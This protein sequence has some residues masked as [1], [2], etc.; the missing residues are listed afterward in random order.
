MM[1]NVENLTSEQSLYVLRFLLH[2][3]GLDTRGA[4]MAEMPVAYARLYPSV[5][6]TV[7][8][9]RVAGSLR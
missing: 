1:S 9:D 8:I 2:R 7:V 4:L 3:M 6:P 5:D